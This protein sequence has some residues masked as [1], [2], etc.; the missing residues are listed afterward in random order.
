MAE[1]FRSLC[2]GQETA[3]GESGM[4]ATSSAIA[5][6]YPQRRRP[7]VLGV[8]GGQFPQKSGGVFFPG[9]ENALV[10]RLEQAP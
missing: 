2:I 5:D 4:G 3:E 9:L 1:L 7:P 6:D 10:S 8:D